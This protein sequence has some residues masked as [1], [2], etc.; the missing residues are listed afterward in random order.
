MAKL[1]KTLVLTIFYAK[2]IGTG[3]GAEESLSL[4]IGEV[5]RAA[6]LKTKGSYQDAWASLQN[7]R[8]NIVAAKELTQKYIDKSESK[9][10]EYLTKIE[11]L[12]KQQDD[13]IEEK[14]GTESKI[15]SNEV[16]IENLYTEIKTLQ[17]QVQ[18]KQEQ[19][20]QL[21]RDMQND[22][23]GFRQEGRSGGL[24]LFNIGGI[25]IRLGSGFGSAPNA[26]RKGNE[27]RSK[28]IEYQS[29]QADLKTS[30]EYKQTQVSPLKQKQKELGEYSLKL[31]T[32]LTSIQS[33]LLSCQNE[34]QTLRN[35]LGIFREAQDLWKQLLSIQETRLEPDMEILSR[36]YDKLSNSVVVPTI[37]AR[38]ERQEL[39]L[40]EAL[41]SFGDLIGNPT[42]RMALVELGITN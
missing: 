33:T 24:E 4:V 29:Q 5:C 6:E 30:I 34:Q 28:I 16:S 37:I 40:K 17:R 10:S 14:K 42:T 35:F 39:R 2:I 11:S 36:V 18:E 3:F 25:S 9:S 38:S 22:K 7:A 1:L 21:E 8:K 26:I 20:D 27:L 23:A 13:L 19:I 32:N 31:Q 15:K 41:G 12:G